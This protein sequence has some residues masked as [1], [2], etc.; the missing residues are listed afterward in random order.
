MAV[1][2]I[3]GV[4]GRIYACSFSL[5]FCYCFPAFSYLF[6]VFFSFPPNRILP[7]IVV[8]SCALCCSTVEWFRNNSA[9]SEGAGLNSH[10][11]TR[12]GP[13]V[14]GPVFTVGV[15]SVQ[16]AA[17]CQAYLPTVALWHLALREVITE[18]AT[19]KSCHILFPG[20]CLFRDD[21]CF[22]GR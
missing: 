12:R 8:A 7:E 1:S 22:G 16:I 18:F 4:S 2:R 14:Q 15:V 17:L 20:V 5:F 10:E 11:H 9:H 13:W 3:S 21:V 6:F 19:S